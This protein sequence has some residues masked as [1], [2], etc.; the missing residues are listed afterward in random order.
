MTSWVTAATA[1][2]TLSVTTSD[3]EVFFTELQTSGDTSSDEFIELYNNSDSAINFS[4]ASLPWKVQFFS[5]TS[6]TSGA[7]DWTKPSA[8]VSLAGTIAPH[9]YYLLASNTSSDGGLYKPGGLDADQGYNPR[10]SD[11][12]GGLQLVTTD[13]SGASNAYDQLMWLQ[14]TAGHALPPKVLATPDAGQSLQRLLNDDAEYVNPDGTL[15]DFVVSQLITPKDMWSPAPVADP[16]PAG[17]GQTD[18]T[19]ETALDTSDTDPSVPEVIAAP[20]VAPII[21]E[22]L[23]NPASPKTDAADE[24]IEVY[25]PNSDA[26]NLKGYSLETGTTTLH[27]FTFTSDVI[28]GPNAY[29]AFYS[30]DTRLS[31]SNSGGEARLLDPSGAAISETS[32][33]TAADDGMVWALSDG[34]WQW[35]T[36]ETPNTANVITMPLP[37]ETTKKATKT[38]AKKSTAKVKGASTT[39]T[40]KPKAAKAKKTKTTTSPVSSTSASVPTTPIHT[41]VLVGVAV[42]AVLYGLYEYR[43]DLANKLHQLRGHRSFGRATR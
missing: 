41:T 42:V 7:P 26:I 1:S 9:D 8:T 3:P 30:A 6:V 40:K 16:A 36:S 2:P 29:T 31:L 35:S 22:L 4:D 28:V 32:V 21:T 34:S 39:K 27:D 20:A 37:A 10:L 12:G 19:D 33:Y 23:P 38:T 14:P 43:H 5:S 13:A 18:T 17:S 25:N 11:S 15:T 24:F